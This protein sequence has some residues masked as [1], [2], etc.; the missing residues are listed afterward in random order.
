M[1]SFSRPV[2]FMLGA[3]ISWTME[4]EALESTFSDNGEEKDV[5]DIFADHKFNWIR[6]RIF[7]NPL[8]GYATSSS[9]GRNV[10]P[11]E[12]FC[13]LEY[14]ISMA[15]RIKEAGMSLLLDFHYSDT[16]ADPG[17][18]QIPQSW[19]G[20]SLEE[21]ADS[22]YAY[23]YHVL[24]QMQAEGVLPHMV[25]VGNE[26]NNGMCRP[27]GA[28]LA[29]A[30]V[31]VKSG[32]DAVHD[33]SPS[34]LTMVHPATGGDNGTSTWFMN[35]MLD[36]GCQFD[37]LGL[38]CYT[39]WHGQP[40]DWESNFTQLAQDFPDHGFII[41]E[42]SHEKQAANDIMFNLPDE[43]GWGTFIWEP[44]S[45][46][47]PIFDM[48]GNVYHTNDLID[49]YPQMYEEYGIEDVIGINPLPDG[50][51]REIGVKSMQFMHG[52]RIMFLFPSPE[53]GSVLMY[54]GKGTQ[55]GLFGIFTQNP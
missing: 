8:N 42:Y 35:T 3:D 47:E 11:R 16:W 22:L 32:L 48:Q 4:Y 52:N 20:L 14:T 2:P 13:G 27:V 37:A 53:S 30:A 44:V 46:M 24:M 51:I 55:N 45:W 5:L 6:L 38:S 15:K 18:Q 34:I 36:G 50:E 10:S 23:T 17:N 26:I 1:F 25:Q 19:E 28:D 43:R 39:Q 49:L 29:D 21:M 9:Y 54:D 33:V 40:E 7:H 31:L 41:V 12:P